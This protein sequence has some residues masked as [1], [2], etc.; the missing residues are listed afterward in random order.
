MDKRDIV[1][2][3]KQTGWLKRIS[4]IH[5]AYLDLQYPLIFTYGEDGFRLGIKKTTTGT[6]THKRQT[7][8]MRQWFAYR[9]HVIQFY[10][11]NDCFSNIWLTLLL[12]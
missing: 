6:A 5:P 3:E 10:I 9:M 4:E 1:L 2:E 12:L 11:L 8:S 7:I